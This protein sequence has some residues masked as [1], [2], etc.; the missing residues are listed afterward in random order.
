VVR[1]SCMVRASALCRLYRLAGHR[2]FEHARLRP[3]N[4]GRGARFGHMPMRVDGALFATK[5]AGRPD[6]ALESRRSPTPFA[7]GMRH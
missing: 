5:T 7:A 4:W 1:A 3:E 2:A 6:Y